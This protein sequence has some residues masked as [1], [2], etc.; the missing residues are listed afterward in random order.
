MTL[1]AIWEEVIDFF[2]SEERT[3][4]LVESSFSV[5][6]G[7][8]ETSEVQSFNLLAPIKDGRKRPYVI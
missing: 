5:K 7:V 8:G 4:R 2:D 6:R 3:L 1:S